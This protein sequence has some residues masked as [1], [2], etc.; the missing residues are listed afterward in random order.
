M[1][2]KKE[3]TKAGLQM[4]IMKTKIKTR[5]KL[6][7][8]KVDNVETE[9]AKDFE[10]LGLIIILNGDCS[11]EIRRQKTWKGSNKGIRRSSSV[12]MY[13]WKSSPGSSILLY[14]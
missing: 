2:V 9:I 11:Q 10:Y 1:K 4:D 14:S 8:F 6:H 13:H 5:E 7:R 12:K 3:S